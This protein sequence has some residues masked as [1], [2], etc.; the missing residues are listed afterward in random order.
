M[1]IEDRKQLLEEAIELVRFSD[2]HLGDEI[3][4]Q[5]VDPLKEKVV[6]LLESLSKII[7]FWK[8]RL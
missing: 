4:E 6:A 1:K 8:C 3:P 5:E 7:S 2:I